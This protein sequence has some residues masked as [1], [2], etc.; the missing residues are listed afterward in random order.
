MEK[1]RKEIEGYVKVI[2]H[3][4][5]DPD[6]EGITTL[7]RSMRLK[8]ELGDKYEIW[9][10]AVLATY[11]DLWVQY[12]AKLGERLERI[13]KEH[14]QD[15]KRIRARL[16]TNPTGKMIDQAWYLFFATGNITYMRDAFEVAG[17]AKIMP[18]IREEALNVY[19]NIKDSFTDMTQRLLAKD[20]HHFTKH[21][22]SAIIKENDQI[23][24]KFQKILDQATR[25]LEEKKAQEEASILNVVQ[26]V[27]ERGAAQ[28][29]DFE[30]NA[31]PAQR[32]ENERKKKD[33]EASELFDRL[34][35]DILSKVK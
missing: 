28:E 8:N 30:E 18:A 20:P 1:Y 19:Q 4:C 17:D 21:L 10:R 14:T 26:K 29:K 23:F 2:Q 27:K 12:D 3:F 7:S 16:L 11:G 31:T 13:K 33:R 34:A 35:R 6:Y 25:E 32:E 9:E 24:A 15:V 5:L 22:A